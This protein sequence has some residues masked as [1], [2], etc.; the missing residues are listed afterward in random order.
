MEEIELFFAIDDSG[1]LEDKNVFC[2]YGGLMFLNSNSRSL[3][4]AKYRALLK[5]IKCKY[6]EC[7]QDNCNNDCPEI[8]S[9]I[10]SNGDRRQL[11]NL[12]KKYYCIVAIIDKNRITK[13][14]SDKKSKRRFLNYSVKMLVKESIKELLK[15]N[16]INVNNNILIKV[17]IDNETVSSNGRYDLQNSIRQELFKGTNTNGLFFPPIL[18]YGDV[19]V[20]YKDS[21]SNIDVQA[22]DFLAGT[23][24]RILIHSDNLS[25]ALTQIQ[26]IVNIVVFVPK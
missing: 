18:K 5:K 11:M 4:I 23:L 10:I 1:K 20:T 2:V 3:F 15:V 13:L 22:A 16:S 19:K 7:S 24:R 9:H 8:K 6:R 21:K 17:N 25:D 12:I 14:S 26:K